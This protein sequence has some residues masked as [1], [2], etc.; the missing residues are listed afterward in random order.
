MWNDLPRNAIN[1]RYNQWQAQK[2]PSLLAVNHPTSWSTQRLDL[3]YVDVE[4]TVMY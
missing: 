1:L 4:Y 2:T 3:A